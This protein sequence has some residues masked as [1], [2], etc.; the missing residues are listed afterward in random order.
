MTFEE[1]REHAKRLGSTV[2]IGTVTASG[3]A[4]I[5]PIAVTWPESWCAEPSPG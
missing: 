1:A 5:T 2:Y 3:F 4:N